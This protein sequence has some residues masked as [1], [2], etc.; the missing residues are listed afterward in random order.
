[1]TLPNRVLVD[2][3]AFYALI[4][5]TDTFHERARQAYERLIDRDLELW[6]TS[7]ILV[8]TIALV[9]SRLGFSVLSKFMA[10]IGSNLSVL[11]EGTV[12]GQAWQRL[13]AEQGHG[14][15]FVDWTAVLASRSLDAHV[16]TFDR[17]FADQGIPVLPR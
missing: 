4:S 9:H 16:F 8:E 10:S 14:L 7:Y 13:Q 3:S 1:M 11:V 17:G 6:T 15:S 2:T 5:Q 12:H